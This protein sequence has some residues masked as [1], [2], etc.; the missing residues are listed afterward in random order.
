MAERGGRYGTGSREDNEHAIAFARQAVSPALRAAALSLALRDGY[1]ADQP[2]TAL[3][4]LHPYLDAQNLKNDTDPA[5]QLILTPPDQTIVSGPAYTAGL[6]T[7]PKDLFRTQIAETLLTLASASLNAGQIRQAVRY[8]QLS[9]EKNHG[10]RNGEEF[11]IADIIEQWGSLPD[12]ELPA[13][14]ML[15]VLHGLEAKNSSSAIANQALELAR[16]YPRSRYAQIA[17]CEAI[18]RARS[19]ESETQASKLKAILLQDYPESIPALAIEMEAA[20]NQ[21]DL[22]R[23][24]MLAAA[25]QS[26]VQGI[27]FT[28]TQHPEQDPVSAENI[29]YRLSHYDRL[30]QQLKPLLDAAHD[31]EVTRMDL[32]ESNGEPLAEALIQRL[33]DRAAEIYRTLIPIYPNSA[34]T[35]RFLERFPSDSWA[36]EAWKRL[37]GEGRAFTPDALRNG[38]PEM[39]QWLAP[40][41][42]RNDANSTAAAKL[43]KKMIGEGQ[44]E[45]GIRFAQEEARM[46]Q[47][48]YPQ[49]R[50]SGVVDLAV[51]QTLLNS[52]RPEAMLAYADRAMALLQ[53]NDPMRGEAE[54]G[55]QR[56]V[57]EIA[58]KRRSGLW[59]QGGSGRGES[60]FSSASTAK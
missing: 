4:L 45:A 40:F 12:A 57:L 11:G 43:L 7:D 55:R 24:R 47:D 25:Y 21:G 34:L 56:A 6:R 33:P 49:S 13:A 32:L 59:S 5:L 22:P 1:L 8:A 16:R 9:P 39:V 28:S 41:V 58:A 37:I 50:A 18:W 14:S 53:Q 23:T 31:P 35:M 26:R 46:V 36:G 15:A 29:A 51:A 44:G 2:Q 10:G 19:D 52:R 54:Q 17:L 30:V 60:I 20:F 48:R 27:N 42:N 38:G 3:A